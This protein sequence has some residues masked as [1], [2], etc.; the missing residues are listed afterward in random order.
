MPCP[1]AEKRGAIVFCK[2]IGGP[3]N[4]LAF[5]CLTGRYEMCRYYREAKAREAEAKAVEIQSRAVRAVTSEAPT[6]EEVERVAGTKAATAGPA[7]TTRGLTVD[8]RPA[9]NCLECVFYS[10][11]TKSCLLLGVKVEDPNNPPCA[12]G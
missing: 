6:R 12:Q 1:Y 8:G 2:A 10:E 5:P 7:P 4:P 11:A 9:R 3:V